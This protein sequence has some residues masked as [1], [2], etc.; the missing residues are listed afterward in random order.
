MISDNSDTLNFRI[1]LNKL[2]SISDN[3][4][5]SYHLERFFFFK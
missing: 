1:L 4:F 3:L 5:S 2:K